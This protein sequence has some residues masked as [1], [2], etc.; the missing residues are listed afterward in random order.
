MGARVY[1]MQFGF[2]SNRK[3]VG[4]SMVYNYLGQELEDDL[5]KTIQKSVPDATVSVGYVD[6][7]VVK[8]DSS[9]YVITTKVRIII[10]GVDDTSIIR[11]AM[12]DL[13]VSAP[14]SL[15]QICN[16]YRYFREGRSATIRLAWVT[17]PPSL[18]K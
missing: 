3:R 12:K 9:T 1:S 11:S 4:S 17:L 2:E 6:Y 14:E 15:I 16:R 18:K 13:E 5:A 8:K 10:N 7:G